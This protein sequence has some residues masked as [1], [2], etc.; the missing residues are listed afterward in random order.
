MATAKERMKLLQ[1]ILAESGDIANIDLHGELAKR[2][3]AFNNR[4]IQTPLNMAMASPQTLQAPI[5]PSVAVQP[6]EQTIMPPNEQNAPISP[7]TPP[8]IM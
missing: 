3:V 6:T 2:L 1:D 5:S 7:N 4:P 8:G